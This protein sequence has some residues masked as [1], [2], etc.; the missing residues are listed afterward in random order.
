MRCEDCD[1]IKILTCLKKDQ[2]AI[3]IDTIGCDK[4]IQRLRS[5]G[6]TRGSKVKMIKNDTG[7]IIIKILG[8]KLAV[9]RALAEKIIIDL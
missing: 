9:D 3:I 5:L 6:I 7:P 1:E 4:G 8:S 2:T